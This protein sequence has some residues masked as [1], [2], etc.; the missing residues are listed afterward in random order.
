MLSEHG[1]AIA[2]HFVAP[3]HLAHFVWDMV[4]ESLD[5]NSI[6]ASYSEERGYQQYHPTLM[7]ALLLYACCQSV[8]SSQRIAKGCAERLDFMAVTA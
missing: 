4:H 6:M 3:D 7:T 2:L 8:D 5:L 1:S